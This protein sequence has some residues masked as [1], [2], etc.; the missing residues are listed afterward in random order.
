[1]Y[2]A[3]YNAVHVQVELIVQGLSP[4]LVVYVVLE[5]TTLA[6]GLPVLVCV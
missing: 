6:Q 2:L 1:M 3:I 5:N 4:V